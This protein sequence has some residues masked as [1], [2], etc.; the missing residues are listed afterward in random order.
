MNILASV[1]DKNGLDSFLKNIIREGDLVYATGKTADFL[2]S[3]GIDAISTSKLS[4][5]DELL[6]GRVKTLVPSIFAGILSNRDPRSNEELKAMKFPQFDMVISNLYPFRAAAT[7]GD[8]NAMIENI[9]IGGVSLI[10][11]AAKN[12]AHVSVVTSR[13]QYE[14]ISRI[15]REKGE[16]PLGVRQELALK[17]FALAASYDIDIYTSL[18]R[19]I[20]PEHSMENLFLGFT[21]GKKLRYGE[22]PD[23]EAYMYSGNQGSGIPGAFQMSGKE[24][25]YNNILDS[26][27]AFET[28]LEFEEP[29]VVIVKHLT[30]CGVA[31]SARLSE[32][33]VRAF[34]AD[35]ESAYGF[36]MASNVEV[37]A[38]TAALIAKNFAEV[39]VAPS[40]SKE[41]FEILRKR[42]NLRILR[43]RMTPDTEMRIRSVSGGIL[44]QTPLRAF[45]IEPV[46]KTSMGATGSDLADLMF[47]WKVVA[48]ARS[49]AIVLAK[50]NAV[51]GMGSG[52]TSRVRAL[53]I[54]GELAG[55][56]AKGSVL[57]SD[58]YFPFSDSVEEAKRLGVVAIIQPGGSIRDNEVIAKCEQYSIPLYFTSKRVFLH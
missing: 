6:G 56:K 43:T 45:P 14:L 33:Y 42:K 35:P 4:G 58:A 18:S 29:T 16:I 17:A 8:L 28:A 1:F 36:V 30:P 57:A 27:A 10:R 19:N 15:I 20:I 25:S 44:A 46:L 41:A 26:N 51:T 50:S 54:A 47:A 21:E 52:Q 55:E 7:S 34:D 38:D 53:K 9:D 32:A 37:D 3:S 48:H 23:Q 24:L 22:N 13:D 40:Y 49:N 11:A 12:Y 39:V 5:F 31:S 2:K